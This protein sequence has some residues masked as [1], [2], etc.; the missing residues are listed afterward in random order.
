MMEWSEMLPEVLDTITQKYITCYEDYLSFAGVCKSWRLATVRTYHNSNGPPSRLPSL[1]LAEKS[2][3]HESRELFLLSNKSIRKIRLPE[4]YGKTCRYS[5]CGWL[6][7]VGKDFASQLIN[8]L[9]REIINLPK[10]DTLSEAIHPIYWQYAILKVVLLLE[11]QSMLILWEF[12]KL[13]FCHIGDNKWTSV[14]HGLDNYFI[15]DITYFNGQVYTFDLNNTIRACN[16]N[17]KDQAVLVHL[18]T[19]PEDVYYRH[20]FSGYIVGLDDAKVECG[21]SHRGHVI[22]FSVFSF[23]LARNNIYGT[24]VL[25][26]ACKGEVGYVYNIRMKRDRRVIDVAKYICKLFNMD[27]NA[28][29]MFVENR[30]FNDQRYF[31]DDEKLKSLG[32]YIAKITKKWSKPDKNEHEIVKS[33]QKPDPKTFSMHKS[34]VKSQIPT[35]GAHSAIFIS[36]KVLRECKGPL[37]GG[38]C[39]F[40][41]SKAENSFTYDPDSFNVTS[42]NFNHLSQPQLCRNNSHYVYD[43]P[44]QFLSI[45]EQEPSYNQ[46][47]NGNYYPHD[48]SS[49]LCCDNCGGSHETFLCLPMDQNID[50]SGFDQIQSSQYSVIHHPSQE[51][52]EDNI[53]ILQVR[54]RL[55]FYNNDEEHSVQYKEYLE[56]SSNAIVA[57][58]FNQEKEKP[59]Q[60]SDIRQ[61]VSKECSIK[62]CEEKKKNMEDTLLELLEVCRQKEF[63]CMHNDGDDLIESALNSKIFSINLRSQRFNKKKKEVK[64]IVKQPTKRGTR[65]AESLQKFRVKKSSTSLNNTSQI[66]PVNAITP[67]LPT[68]EPEYSLSMG[69]EHLN[70][71]SKMESD[72]VIES[73]VKN[74]IQIPREYEVISNDG[75]ECDMPIKDEYSPAFTTFSNP[76]FDYNDDFTSSDDKSLSKEDVPMENFKVFLN[77]LFDDEEINSDE[78]DLHHFNAESDLIESL[79]N[80]DTFDYLKEISGELMPTSIANEERIKRGHEEYISHM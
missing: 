29:I 28:S 38:F 4:I 67:V 54:N 20:V 26:E 49:F 69:Y 70:T 27:A 12:K 72:K 71:I 42:S 31:L 61:L 7:T 35:Q 56:N 18:A 5:S 11:S 73:S 25:L 21:L 3:D 62:V 17:G 23:D 45:Y 6:L 55:T 53:S 34:Q 50:S 33:A 80:H 66:S 1:M 14:E 75:N 68:E 8:P 2:D 32:T 36:L 16:V 65:I 79:S 57:T 13:W 60:N 37:R 74:L 77:S 15:Y 22:A 19:L 51:M 10:I 59:P 78:I 64:N 47:Y 41:N 63:Y 48:S 39:L 9:S 43:Y 76:L 30:P 46:N 24:H 44:P 40:C 52:S 58:N